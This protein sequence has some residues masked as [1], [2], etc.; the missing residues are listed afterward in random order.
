MVHRIDTVSKPRGDEYV[1]V[2]PTQAYTLDNGEIQNS[3]YSSFLINACLPLSITIPPSPQSEIFQHPAC[4]TD[5]RCSSILTCI[6]LVI[7]FPLL[8][9]P[10]YPFEDV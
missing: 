4:A 7:V 2:L 5:E 10:L 1:L 9:L 6:Q 3:G 8:L